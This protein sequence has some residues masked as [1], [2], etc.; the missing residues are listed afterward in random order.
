[1]GVNGFVGGVRQQ[2]YYVNNPLNLKTK[3]EGVGTLEGR[4]SWTNHL[5]SAVQVI[6]KPKLAIGADKKKI[7]TGLAEQLIKN[8]QARQAAQREN[9]ENHR[10]LTTKS[11]TL[12]TLG[13][14]RGALSECGDQRDVGIRARS[15]GVTGS[16]SSKT[17]CEKHEK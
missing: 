7:F 14:F 12:E 16:G 13:V 1:M 15:Y 6:E 9:V 2:K 10:Q 5:K 11:R 8:Y 4:K 3:M 17:A